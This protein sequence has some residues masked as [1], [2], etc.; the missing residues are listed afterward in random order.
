[1]LGL[2]GVPRK[3]EIMSI[4]IKNKDKNKRFFASIFSFDLIE[5]YIICRIYISRKIKERKDIIL[6]SFHLVAIQSKKKM[7]PEK[8]VVNFKT[9]DFVERRTKIAKNNMIP[10]VNPKN[11]EFDP[12]KRRS[13]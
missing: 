6:R 7:L 4:G 2:A 3:S 11:P 8:M 9:I 13:R 1:M 5:T 12:V 10:P